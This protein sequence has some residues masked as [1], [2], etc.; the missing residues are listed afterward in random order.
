MILL[1]NNYLKQ[2][3]DLKSSN[4]H[5]LRGGFFMFVWE[6]WQQEGIRNVESFI[7]SKYAVR[8]RSQSFCHKKIINF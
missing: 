8:K 1:I 6:Q 7:F 5:A 3:C 2:V 4:A